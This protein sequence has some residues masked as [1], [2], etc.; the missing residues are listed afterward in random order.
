MIET[1]TDT[2]T[3]TAPT[4]PEPGGDVITM[5]GSFQIVRG[6]VCP[7]TPISR[8]IQIVSVVES[9]FPDWMNSCNE[10]FDKNSQ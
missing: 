10:A 5:G 6:I 8:G 7:E 2:D 1:N 4:L 3:D 9:V